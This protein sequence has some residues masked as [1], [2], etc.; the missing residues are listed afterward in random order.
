MW[1]PTV[2]STDHTRT[3]RRVAPGL[4]RAA[5]DRGDAAGERVV[6]EE[7]VQHDRVG[8]RARRTR[9]SARRSR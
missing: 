7:R 1:S 4:L 3:D 2:A 5:A 8:D 9:A 6:G